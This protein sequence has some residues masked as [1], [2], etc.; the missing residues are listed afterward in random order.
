MCTTLEHDNENLDDSMEVN[1]D[2]HDEI[3]KELTEE[4]TGEAAAAAVAA[5]ASAK[6]RRC[7]SN[8]VTRYPISIWR[9][10]ISILSSFTSLAHIPYRYPGC[11]Y[12]YSG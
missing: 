6:V 5:L 9:M 10:T 2:L 7:V 3:V 11:P 4:D 8:R 1:E 12:R